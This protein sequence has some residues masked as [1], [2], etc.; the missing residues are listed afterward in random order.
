MKSMSAALQAHYSLGTT[1][2]ATCWKATLV[3]GTVIASTSLDQDLVFDGVTYTATNSYY[4]SNID[5]S[6]EL[7]PDNLEVDGFLASPLI[8]DDDI[9]SGL[10]DYATIELFEVNYRDLA[11]GKNILRKGTLGQVKA[12]R[13][14]FTAELRGVMQAYTNTIVRITTKNCTADLGDERCTVDLSTCSVLGSVTTTSSNRNITAAA[15]GQVIN[16]F[17]GGKIT[18][19]SGL[20]TGLTMEVKNNPAENVFELY[21]QMPFAIAIGDTFIVS[22]GCAKR[23]TEDCKNKFN[24]VLNFRGFPHLPGSDAYKYGGQ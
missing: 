22:A 23:F 6:L 11:M 16:F 13:S 7:N 12:G 10:W 1:T 24:N 18:F 15:T 9:Y 2:L 17:T 20:N 14:S 5:S 8:S 4:P 19:A 21:S 3:N